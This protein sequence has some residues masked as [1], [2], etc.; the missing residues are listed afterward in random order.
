M[1]EVVGGRGGPHLAPV[2]AH[3]LLAAQERKGAVVALSAQRRADQPS[4]PAQIGHDVGLVGARSRVA[5]P[6]G[7]EG[8]DRLGEDRVELHV[9]V[10]AHA[11]EGQSRLVGDHDPGVA[12]EGHREV[13][14][15][16]A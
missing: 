13:A 9:G 16:T 10:E 15:E 5:A 7:V 4:G 11:V 8:C 6:R 2:H 3:A 12:R 1:G 14:V